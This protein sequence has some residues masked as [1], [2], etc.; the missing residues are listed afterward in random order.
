MNVHVTLIDLG[1]HLL[2]EHSN[3][4]RFRNKTAP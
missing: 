3:P 4:T 1:H 2:S